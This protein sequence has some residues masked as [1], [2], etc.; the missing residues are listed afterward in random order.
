MRPQ[1]VLCV[2]VMAGK[3]REASSLLCLAFPLPMAV[4]LCYCEPVLTAS[5]HVFRVVEP[6]G[7]L[8]VPCIFEEREIGSSASCSRRGAGKDRGGVARP[9]LSLIESCEKPAAEQ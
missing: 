9:M 6:Y 7:P 3:H 4:M 2:V 1:C 5:V 8:S